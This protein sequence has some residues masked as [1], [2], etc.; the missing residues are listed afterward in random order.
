MKRINNLETPAVRVEVFNPLRMGN[1]L[2]REIWLLR[3][4]QDVQNEDTL[5]KDGFMTLIK[6]YHPSPYN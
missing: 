2:W 5:D 1:Y 4:A 3:G 6:G